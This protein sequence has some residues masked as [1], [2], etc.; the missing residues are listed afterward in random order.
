MEKKIIELENNLIDEV[1][2]DDREFRK[3][4]K[5]KQIEVLKESYADRLNEEEDYMTWLIE[6]AKANGYKAE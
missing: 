4:T 2:K 1:G 5:E 3:M 6:T